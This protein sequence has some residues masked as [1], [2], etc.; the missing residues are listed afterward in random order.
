ML[1]LEG[2]ASLRRK[3]R[4]PFWFACFTDS[5]GRRTQRSTKQSDRKKAQA[6]ANQFEKAAKMASEHRLGEA[7]ARRVLSD[8][9]E[10]IANEPL[11]AVTA[12]SFL[13]DWPEKKKPNVAHGTYNAYAQT[14][15]DFLETLGPKADRDIS[16]IMR[17]DIAKF[18]DKVAGRT[19]TTNAN[20]QLKYLRVALGAAWKDGLMQDNPAAKV[21]RLS[22]RDDGKKGR[23][24]F[25]LAE[26]KTVV[27]AAS[28]EWKGI[29]MFGL[30]TGQRLSD[31]CSLCWSNLDLEA[32]VIRFVTAKT[33]RQMEIP[34]APPLMEYIESMPSS[35]NPTAPLFSNAYA[36]ATKET[37]DSRLSQQFYDLLVSVGLATKRTKDET[38]MGRARRR[39]VSEITFHSLRHTATSL[40]KNAGVAEAVA[41]DII[42]HESD[43]V[44]RTY[45]HIDD[46]AKRKALRK[47]PDVTKP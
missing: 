15:R 9:Y 4:S 45:T 3:A 8:I 34:I 5:D 36:I 47:L 39:N 1:P 42:G 17:A 18:R 23:R 13:T 32:E 27:A 6:V 22:E 33:G 41:K 26:L 46:R 7:Q 40:L 44:S 12:K 10:A 21:D 35:D 28:G 37:S 29:I 14:C 43:A 38:G 24:P 16:Q 25:T 19:T 30:Y 20:K 11:A 2:M 31:I